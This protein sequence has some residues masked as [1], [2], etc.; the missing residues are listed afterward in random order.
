M[1]IRDSVFDQGEI[2]KLSQIVIFTN[3][4]FASL[5]IVALDRPP[6]FE[7]SCESEQKV[8]RGFSEF[9]FFLAKKNNA[10]LISYILSN[11][12]LVRVDYRG[13][14]GN[15]AL[16]YAAAYGSL[17]AAQV[18]VAAG[19]SVVIKNEMGKSPLDIAKILQN[20]LLVELLM[21]SKTVPPEER[22]KER[23]E[24]T[25]YDVDRLIAETKS[26]FNVSP[27]AGFRRGSPFEKDGITWFKAFF[28][29]EW[30]HQE[31]PRPFPALGEREWYRPYEKFTRP[32][33]YEGFERFP[34][35][36]DRR[37]F[38]ND[39]LRLRR[40]RAQFP[41]HLEQELRQ[42]QDESDDTEPE[43]DF[44][45]KNNSKKKDIFE[46]LLQ[47]KQLFNKTFTI[48]VE[49]EKKREQS[50]VRHGDHLARFSDEQKS[51]RE[52]YEVLVNRII[53]QQTQVLVAAK[54]EF[55]EACSTI[56]QQFGSAM[57]DQCIAQHIFRS[58]NPFSLHPDILQN[59][60]Q[61]LTE[62][63]KLFD[64]LHT[65]YLADIPKLDGE[66]RKL[67]VY[68]DALGQDYHELEKDKQKLSAV[69]TEHQNGIDIFGNPK[70]K[71][72]SRS[73]DLEEYEKTLT[74]MSTLLTYSEEELHALGMLYSH[75]YMLHEM[76][77]EAEL[78][79]D[80]MI[81]AL[82]N[83]SRMQI[84]QTALKIKSLI[85]RLSSKKHDI[86]EQKIDFENSINRPETTEVVKTTM[87]RMVQVLENRL[88]D[89]HYL[90]AL[91]YLTIDRA[92]NEINAI[93]K[94]HM[95][96]AQSLED[97][98]SI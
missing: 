34:K 70:E 98:L 73:A 47:A 41:P 4:I 89:Y 17:D 80:Q 97:R 7:D 27:V 49:Q 14:K 10:S 45:V 69:I 24:R 92:E 22:K 82:A 71:E 77:Q 87:G 5:L 25:I 16:H 84:S 79:T 96:C 78:F 66:I 54:Q 52:H 76:A 32:A 23:H 86:N 46:G 26:D 88:Y 58:V 72:N 90:I 62:I 21:Q 93:E 59:P 13:E 81:D 20:K 48:A 3:I 63:K 28:E 61:S 38:N 33:T 94:E 51:E 74:Y 18:L 55:H 39:E 30:A 43:E 91:L 75:K 64:Q 42:R 95:L 57:L 29:P 9:I 36:E 68:Q 44:V 12:P 85:D 37:D 19:A 40:E 11:N 6:T 2:M 60:P 50:V 56:A 67:K 8:I 31:F 35:Q 15:T 65:G 83:C 53:K 1:G